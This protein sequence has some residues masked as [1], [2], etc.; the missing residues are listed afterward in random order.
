MIYSL[1]LSKTTLNVY[2]LAI[3]NTLWVQ[4]KVFNFCTVRDK[5]NHTIVVMTI[6][7]SWS[8]SYTN[9]NSMPHMSQFYASTLLK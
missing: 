4:F 8:L 3:L 6:T 1:V 9:L 2:N 7:T 5:I